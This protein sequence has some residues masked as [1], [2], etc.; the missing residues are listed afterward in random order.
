MQGRSSIFIWA[1]KL[2]LF[3]LSC[4]FAVQNDSDS[5]ISVV[6]LLLPLDSLNFKTRTVSSL[7]LL[8]TFAALTQKKFKNLYPLLRFAARIYK[9]K[10]AHNTLQK[11]GY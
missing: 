8:C 10:I 2:Q 7:Y 4:A 9:L 1:V 6:L 3:C 11:F 5:L